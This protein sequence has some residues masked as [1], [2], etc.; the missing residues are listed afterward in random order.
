MRKGFFVFGLVV[1]AVISS[2]VAQGQTITW[3]FPSLEPGPGYWAPD[4]IMDFSKAVKERTKGRLV[5]NLYYGAELGI[6]PRDYLSALKKGAIQAAHASTAYY[7]KEIEGCAISAMPMVAVGS[8]DE[9]IKLHQGLKPFIN[10]QLEKKYNVRILWMIPWEFVQPLTKKKIESF[11]NL[12]GMKLRVSGVL[13][14]ELIK[15]SNGVP[16]SMPLSEVYTS[17][18]KGVI[19]GAI[20][21]IPGLQNASLHEV[22]KYVYNFYYHSAASIYLVS[23]DAFNALPKEIQQIVVEEAN[24]VEAKGTAEA[25]KGMQEGIAFAKSKPNLE[26]IDPQMKEVEGVRKIVKPLWDSWYK[27]ASPA[28][29][30]EFVKALERTGIAYKP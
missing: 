13:T 19:D 8:Y 10:D 28:G 22:V 30:A 1:V 27:S 18:S 6:N 26:V 24:R 16:V 11:S 4:V 25:S 3:R 29:Q 14:G 12:G 17:L 2:S 15:A 21:S 5:V 7:A 9:T 20:C 23:I